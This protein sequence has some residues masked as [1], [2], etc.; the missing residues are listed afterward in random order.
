[1]VKRI[2]IIED[3]R[4]IL[5]I[6]AF[7]LEKEG[8][9]VV[10]ASDG[11]E[12]LVTFAA[13]HFDLVLLD[14]MMPKLDGLS[15]LDAIRA[16]A[17]VPVIIMSAKTAEDDRLDGFAR[18]ADD[19]IC[20]PFSVKELVMRVKVH[21]SRFEKSKGE[22]LRLIWG[23]FELDERNKTVFRNGLPVSFSKKEFQ[24]ILLF[25]KNRNRVYTREELM[26]LVWGYSP[27]QPEDRTVDVA[28]RRLREKMEE[29][30]S[31]P[32]YI[33]SKRGIGYQAGI[34]K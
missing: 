12:G 7:N 27:S 13:Q 28:I 33:I 3:D 20:K 21:L 26:Q 15:V 4:N 14:I 18:Q 16:R 8:Y 29:D 23:D 10:L 11:E 1:M 25:A 17:D 2:L 34:E 9:E 32:R 24:L 19:Y 5:D 31:H 30:P 22:Q 6:V